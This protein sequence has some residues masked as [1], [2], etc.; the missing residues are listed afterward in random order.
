M[1]YLTL[2][3]CLKINGCG[4]DIDDRIHIDTTTCNNGTCIHVSVDIFSQNITSVTPQPTK[5]VNPQTSIRQP[6]PIYSRRV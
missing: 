1:K 5:T 3:D 2:I 6:T 4:N